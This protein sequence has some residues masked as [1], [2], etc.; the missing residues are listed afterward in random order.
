M[1]LPPLYIGSIQSMIA[2]S[3]DTEP[4]QRDNV[5]CTTKHNLSFTT[6]TFNSGSAAL[7]ASFLAS[8]LGIGPQASTKLQGDRALTMLFSRLDT[9]EWYP[10][11][12][13]L[14]TL[15]D[16]PSVSQYLR[17]LG[18]FHS[19]EVFV[20]TGVKV[21]YG[22]CAESKNARV[23]EARLDLTLD[24]GLTGG[25]PGVIELGLQTRLKRESTTTVL[26]ESSADAKEDPGF[27]FA[28]KVQ[29]VKVKTKVKTEN[30]DIMTVTRNKEYIRGALYE[31]FV[32][33]AGEPERFEIDM[34]D[35][36]NTEDMKEDTEATGVLFEAGDGSENIWV[37]PQ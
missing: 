1:P 36:I 11:N 20:I 19:K 12:V 13:E 10:S 3:A 9:H 18:S 7:S 30:G 28:Y 17:Y 8:V 34:K 14:Q 5:F 21:A 6:S 35:E 16:L 26:W 37:V 24:P 4:V 22:S 2:S 23:T 27:V 15:I 33:N 31:N 32:P 29:R 25:V